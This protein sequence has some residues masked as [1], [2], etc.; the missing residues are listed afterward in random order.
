MS[1]ANTP[2][3]PARGLD[4]R[5]KGWRQEGILRMLENTVANGEKPEELIIYAGTGKV[6]RDWR[7]FHRIVD[8]LQHLGDDQTLLV[9]SGKP[10]AVFNT[11]PASPRVLTANT[12]LVGKWAT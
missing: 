12:N 10:V 11:T 6:A 3:K 8:V 1:I 7:C 4:L 5:C 2:V 9:Q